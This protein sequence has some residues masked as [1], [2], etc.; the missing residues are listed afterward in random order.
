MATRK[1]PSPKEVP[2]TETQDQS[3]PVESFELI[4][5]EISN[6]A[7]TTTTLLQEMLARGDDRRYAQHWG[8]NE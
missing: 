3:Q 5:A 7:S 2:S 1:M 8:I 4:T 6:R